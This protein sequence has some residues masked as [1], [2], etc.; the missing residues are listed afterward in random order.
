MSDEA[1][2]EPGSFPYRSD[3]ERERDRHLLIEHLAVLVVREH[4]RRLAAARHQ[5]SR[6]DH[7]GDRETDLQRL[8]QSRVKSWS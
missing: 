4:R 8:I 3:A 5:S 2:I 6:T 1:P 7:M